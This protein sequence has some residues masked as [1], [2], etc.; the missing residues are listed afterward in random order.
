[1][2][3][4]V[5]LLSFIAT[6]AG[7]VDY[8]PDSTLG[9]TVMPQVSRP[10]YL[11]PITDPV[12]KTT[13]MRVSDRGAPFNS[14]E[15][16]LS[17][18]YSKNQPW[19]SNGTRVMLNWSY[20][21]AVLDGSTFALRRW[22]R[23]PS[24][25]MWLN[26][27]PR[28][29]IGV[30]GNNLVR[31]EVDADVI[32]TLKSFPEYDSITL[33]DYEGNL[34]RDDKWMAL[35][36]TK[37]ANRE[38]FVFDM[39]NRVVT[40]RMAIGSGPI[41]NTAMSQSGNYVTVQ[42]SVDGSANR[43]GIEVFDR[44]LNRLRQV[45]VRGGTHHDLGYDTNGQEVIVVTSDTSS[46]LIM[47]RLSDGGTTELIPASQMS[48]NIHVS[49]RNLNR[50]GW[51]YVSEF[52]GDVDIVKDNT[53]RVMAVKLDGSGTV[54]NFAHEH[55]SDV[56]AYERAAMA[57]PNRDGSQV[58]FASDWGDGNAPIY[59]YVTY[60]P[61]STPNA[62]PTVALTAPATG[63]TG[64][65]IALSAT[66]ADPDGSIAK[67][68]FFIGNTP[69]STDTTAPYAASWTPNQAGSYQVTAKATDNLGA[70]AVSMATTTVAD[71]GPPP[72]AGI[73]LTV[74][75]AP[76]LPYNGTSTPVTVSF[77]AATPTRVELSRDGQAP[78]G[79]WPSNSFFS[80]APDGRS[81]KGSWC[82]T[83]SCWSYV[84]GVHVLKAVATYANGNTATA[85]IT[86][87]VGSEREGSRGA[88]SAAAR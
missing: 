30:S 81:L 77:T 86:L 25:S 34:S 5:L 87:N 14:N 53:Q 31:L 29:A 20:P 50:P 60:Q 68:E 3:I 39:V 84:P 73:S 82:I 26:T 56:Y 33:G 23:Q 36:G 7:A 6:T 58:M 69:L 48:W 80:L 40:A 32:S 16:R 51:A 44:N 38:V 8:P 12:F 2:K 15:L 83:A 35:I 62:S 9:P 46:A 74:V 4:L 13:V 66:A 67:V 19:N 64:N 17:H 45:S 27:D 72:A 85:S 37:G 70:S 79:I 78:F 22:V 1:M 59:A 42:W 21:A 88:P 54:Q 63:T 76:N 75:G 55:R 47:R 52:R 11:A 71:P 43:Q 24:E 65:P 18:T 61:A 49:C 10:G 57:V 41:N 28:Y